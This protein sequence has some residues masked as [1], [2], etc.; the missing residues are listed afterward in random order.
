[1][2]LGSTGIYWV[3]VWNV[4]EGRFQ[5]VLANAQQLKKVPGHKDDVSDAEWIAQCQQRGLLKASFIPTA[6]VR[7]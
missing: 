1:M 5:L 6:Q 2:A 4:L 7:G 3:P